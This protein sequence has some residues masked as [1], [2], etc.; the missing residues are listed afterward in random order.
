[1]NL[2]IED[3]KAR[4]TLRELARSLGF[5]P[6]ERDGVA[7]A[8]FWPERHANGCPLYQ[9]DAAHDLL[10]VELGGRRILKKKTPTITPIPRHKPDNQ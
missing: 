9:Y 3:A 5:V 2:S 6:P 10:R 8:C 7:V 4:L 1:M